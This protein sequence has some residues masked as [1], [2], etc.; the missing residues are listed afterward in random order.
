MTP[1]ADGAGGYILAIDPGPIHSAYVLIDR[2]RRPVQ[3]DKIEND[4][5][6]VL[7]SVWR[8]DKIVIEM[9]ASYGMPV[10]AEV[11]DTCVWIGRFY[12]RCTPEPSLVFRQPVKLHHCQSPRA[13]DA[14]IA[15]ALVDRF[16]KGI[17]NHGKGSKKDPGW[18]YGFHKDIWQ[19]YALA[20]YAADTEEDSHAD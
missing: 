4:D 2:D 16:A 1:A 14:N 18:F 5:L 17:P 8:P 11:F 3:F 12:E 15:Q 10:G 13:N 19:A 7:L 20:V 9:V 6:M